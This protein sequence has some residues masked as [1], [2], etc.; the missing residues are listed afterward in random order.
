M[1]IQTKKAKPTKEKSPTIIKKSRKS[2]KSHELQTDDL[3]ENQKLKKDRSNH[4]I[5]FINLS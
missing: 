2:Q 4:R 1:L 3:E 5:E